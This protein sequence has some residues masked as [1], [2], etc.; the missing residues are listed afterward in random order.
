V[1]GH[2]LGGEPGEVLAEPAPEVDM[3]A[4]GD[5]RPLRVAQEGSV[6]STPPRGGG[7]LE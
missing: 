6:D 1:G 3:P 5:G 4:G 2:A 7:V